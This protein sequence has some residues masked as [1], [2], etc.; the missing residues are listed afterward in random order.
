MAGKGYTKAAEAVG[1]K[2]DFTPEQAIELIKKVK[3]GKFDETV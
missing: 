3:Y 1:D 2:R